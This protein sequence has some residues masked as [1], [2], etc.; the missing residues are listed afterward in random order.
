MVEVTGAIFL[1]IPRT[2]FFGGLLLC[3]TMLV[4]LAIH[5]LVIGGSPVPAIVAAVLSGFVAYRLRPLGAALTDSGA[6]RPRGTVMPSIDGAAEQHP[7]TPA[8]DP[9]TVGGR[10]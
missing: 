6:T 8:A 5:L 7:N 9:R 10:E 2:G 3:V 1:L 4:A